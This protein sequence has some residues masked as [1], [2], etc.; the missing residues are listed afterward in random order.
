MLAQASQCFQLSVKTKPTSLYVFNPHLTAIMTQSHTGHKFRMSVHY[1]WIGLQH[2]EVWPWI[3][4]GLVC[5]AFGSCLQL[6][7]S[8]PAMRTYNF[9]LV[10]A[11]LPFM[12]LASGLIAFECHLR[13]LTHEETYA[14]CGAANVIAFVTL[15]VVTSWS[16][17]TRWW[18]NRNAKL[19]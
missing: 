18:Q 7:I 8:E 13:D 1:V 2:A 17:L 16:K 9:A 5:A 10:S 19:D 15:P 11:L 12:T 4:I 3:Q 6:L 14:I